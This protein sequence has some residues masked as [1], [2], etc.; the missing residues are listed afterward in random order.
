MK[1]ITH[2]KA[3][4]LLTLAAAV[5]FACC[6]NQGNAQNAPTVF[7][8]VDFMKVKPENE[9]KYLDIEKNIWKPL[10]QE[11]LKKGIITGWILYKVLY[12]GTNDPYNYVTVTFFDNQAK[13]EDPWK[14]IEAVKILPGRDLNKDMEETDKSRDLVKS[15][16]IVR[17]DEVIPDGGP[18]EVKY[19]EVD[20]MKVKPGNEGAYVAA[21]E[22]IWVPIHKEFIKAGTRAGWS[23]WGNAF[24]SGAGMDYQYTTVNYF[25][26][27][28]K[29]G[30]ADYT[31]AFEKAHKGK[32]MDELGKQTTDL[33]DLVRS[34]L[35][36][37]LDV[38]MKP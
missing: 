32:S 6:P 31:A 19:I 11:R 18:G 10:H 23:L 9:G 15:H 17:N 30:M 28:S 13:L 20:F 16:L 35:W 29:I 1:T 22:N 38:V 5:L 4:L 33:R 34:E 26:D 14:D 21:E 24:P 2:F 7:A 37:T 3:T 27:F 25:A 12:T 36:Q 8:I